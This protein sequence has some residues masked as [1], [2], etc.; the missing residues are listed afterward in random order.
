MR[1]EMQALH[2]MILQVSTA[3]KLWFLDGKNTERKIV[4]NPNIGDRAERDPVNDA[5]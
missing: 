3:S 5:S 4:S 1:G 2:D